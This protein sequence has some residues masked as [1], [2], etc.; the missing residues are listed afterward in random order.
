MGQAAYNPGMTCVFN[1]SR[2]ACV[3]LLLVALPAWAQEVAAASP[4]DK[5][6]LSRTERLHH[7]DAGSKVDELRVGGLTRRID[8]QTKNGAG[9]TYH[10]EP[11]ATPAGAASPAGER[12]GHSGGAGRSSW[13][14]LQF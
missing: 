9:S 11:S 8:V 6:R 3:G 14:V 5:E 12:S 13:R 1:F 7:E 10:I 2:A 4:A